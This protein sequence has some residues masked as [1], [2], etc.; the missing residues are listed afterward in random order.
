MKK[1]ILFLSRSGYSGN[2]AIASTL[3]WLA[4]FTGALFDNYY[5]TYHQGGHFGGGIPGDLEAG[6]LTG[7]TVLGDRHH[8]QLYFILLNFDISVISFGDRLMLS[9]VKNMDIPIAAKSECINVLYRETFEYFNVPIPSDIVMIGSDFTN[10]LRGLEGY[11]YPEIYYRRGIGVHESISDDELDD[12]CKE[13]SRIVCIYVKNAKISELQRKGYNIEIVDRIH[14]KD[15]Y[16]SISK[17]IVMRWK[18]EVEGWILGDPL[19]ASYWIPKACEENLLAIYSIP[20][21]K[22]SLN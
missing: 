5:D 19:L 2:V 11:L 18:D 6:A 14:E 21:R 12:L 7:G 3:A 1:L 17:R 8:E 4:K 9:P 16:C 10:E 20:S 22:L 13:G 15:D